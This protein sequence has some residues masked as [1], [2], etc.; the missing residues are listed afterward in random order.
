MLLGCS[1][2]LFASINLNTAS[3]DEL[4]NIKGI[5]AKK[6]EKILVF[7]KTN[8]ITQADDLKSIKGFGPALIKKIQEYASEK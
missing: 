8:K 5:G 7:R 1:M 6:A 2:F 3:K 4:M